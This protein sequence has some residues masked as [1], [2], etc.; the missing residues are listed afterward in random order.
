MTLRLALFALCIGLA[1]A[2]AA[3]A[4]VLIPAANEPAEAS[5]PKAVRPQINVPADIDPMVAEILARPVFTSTRMPAEM[6]A[7]AEEEL[8]EPKQPPQLQARLAG[9]SLGPDAREAL[10][11]RDSGEM[12]ETIPVKVGG[13][14]DG[15]K[16]SA[17][18]LDGVVL[19]SEFGRQVV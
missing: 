9:I 18:Q 1:S 11:Q 14:I 7:A 15:W 4:Y 2:V 13:E 16:V 12:A 19:T 6:P 3:E 17:I 8:V 10:F 5:A